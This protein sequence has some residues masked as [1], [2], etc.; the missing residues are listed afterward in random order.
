MAF[1]YHTLDL[2]S[3]IFCGNACLF[4]LCDKF[5]VHFC[6]VSLF[7]KIFL[8]WEQRVSVVFQYFYIRIV[9]WQDI[10]KIVAVFYAHVN[11]IVVY[12]DTRVKIIE[13][14]IHI[15]IV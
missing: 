14:Y 7:I 8:S 1:L 12:F 13:I 15:K 2:L 3:V 10:I 5:S 11:I 9:V 4:C 6:I